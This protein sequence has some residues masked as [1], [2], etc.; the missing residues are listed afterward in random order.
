MNCDKLST[1]SAHGEND[2]CICMRGR[3]LA[4]DDATALLVLCSCH[5]ARCLG[6]R[7]SHCSFVA[8]SE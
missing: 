2:T 6:S 8:A 4:L 5:Y 1:E 7:H 3:A